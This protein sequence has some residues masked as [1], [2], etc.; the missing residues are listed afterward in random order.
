MRLK[1][2]AARIIPEIAA[3]GA[4]IAVWRDGAS[5]GVDS[6]TP[7]PDELRRNLADVVE[8]D[9]YAVILYAQDFTGALTVDRVAEQMRAHY[10]GG[11]R[12]A[13]DYVPSET[14]AV[15]RTLAANGAAGLS[16]FRAAV[17]AMS[18][19][20]R[21]WLRQVLEAVTGHA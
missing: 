16:W 6:I 10:Y 8:I 1:Q 5:W 15:R 9:P 13:A 3:G 20:E 4:A 7:T 19:R 11:S 2:A 21:G 17:A 14:A 12:R 18:D